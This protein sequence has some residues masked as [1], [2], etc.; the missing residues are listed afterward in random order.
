[1]LERDALSVNKTLV[2]VL[3]KVSA[4]TKRPPRLRVVFEVLNEAPL[5]N[6]APIGRVKQLNKL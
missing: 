4:T 3:V 6:V 2:L 5:A 1:M